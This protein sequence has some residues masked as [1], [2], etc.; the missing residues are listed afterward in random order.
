MQDDAQAVTALRGE[1]VRKYYWLL[2]RVE[3]YEDRKFQVKSWSITACGVAFATA[4]MNALPGL[5]LVAVVGS[6][7]FWY[8]DSS[9]RASQDRTA[10]RVREIDKLLRDNPSDLEPAAL[11]TGRKG[12]WA[13]QAL[14]TLG[15]AFYLHTALP[16]AAIVFAGLYLYSDAIGFAPTSIWQYAIASSQQ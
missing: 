6:V 8:I 10:Q 9:L 15:S 12:N 3:K 7:I 5:L 1:A 11:Y 16:H 13:K 4:L 14:Q 2:D